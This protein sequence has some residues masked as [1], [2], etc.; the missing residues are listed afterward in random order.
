VVRYAD[1]IRDT[2]RI[3][4][5]IGEFAGLEW[6]AQVEQRVAKSL[7]VSR[8]TLSA[9]SPNKWR[10]QEQEISQWLPELAEIIARVER[11]A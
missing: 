5:E 9:P 4:N 11:I 3:L 7:P 8:F 1:L 6:D 10:K 2:K